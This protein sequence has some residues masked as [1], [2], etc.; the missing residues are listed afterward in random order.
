MPGVAVYISCVFIFAVDRFSAKNAKINVPQKFS[1]FT[2]TP[3]NIILLPF[4]PPIEQTP[5]VEIV[6]RSKVVEPTLDGV[7]HEPIRRG[8]S[9]TSTLTPHRF[10][11]HLSS[12]KNRAKSGNSSVYP[13][14]S[15][16][17][18]GIYTCY[19]YRKGLVMKFWGGSDK[20]PPRSQ[21]CISNT[22]SILWASEQSEEQSQEW[23]LVGV[24]AIIK[25]KGRD[26]RY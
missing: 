18:V 15:R 14:S 12:L 13:P 26:H 9:P 24:S 16:G 5:H 11:G 2:V 19:Y 20:A 4:F 7:C 23:K 25:R 3:R 10:Y 8:S 17:K 6:Y 22:A 1:T 21:S